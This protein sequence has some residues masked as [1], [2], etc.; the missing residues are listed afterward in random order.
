MIFKG[1]VIG[2]NNECMGISLRPPY[3]TNIASRGIE[4]YPECKANLM[5]LVQELGFDAWCRVVPMIR[6]S[7]K[8]IFIPEWVV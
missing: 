2:Y 3:R 4:K 6:I 1:T 7:V 5:R 8:Y